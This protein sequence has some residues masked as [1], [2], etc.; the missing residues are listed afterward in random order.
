MNIDVD[1]SYYDVVLNAFFLLRVFAA[2]PAR[3]RKSRWRRFDQERCKPMLYIVGC[4]GSFGFFGLLG[5]RLLVA[6]RGQERLADQS[7][8]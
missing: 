6:R 7:A 2:R 1:C 3:R 5:K 4:L 8:H